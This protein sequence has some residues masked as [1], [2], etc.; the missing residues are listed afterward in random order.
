VFPT[1]TAVKSEKRRSVAYR[2]YLR[3][4]LG[5]TPPQTIESWNNRINLYEAWTK[6]EKAEELRAKLTQIEDFHK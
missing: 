6:P 4:K 2:E 1:S 5:D 3:L